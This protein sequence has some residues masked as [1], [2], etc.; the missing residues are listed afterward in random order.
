MGQNLGQI[1]S[2]LFLHPTKT[3][4]TAR[5]VRLRTRSSRSPGGEGGALLQSVDG[6]GNVTA[7]AQ[8][9][10]LLRMGTQHRSPA[11]AALIACALPIAFATACVGQ[12]DKAAS[13]SPPATA[14]AAPP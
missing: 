10:W 13:H 2:A 7:C 11:L 3:K 4:R 8:C 5:A 1:Q 12:G 14:R 6:T 9:R